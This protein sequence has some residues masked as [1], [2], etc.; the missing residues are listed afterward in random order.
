[1]N[2]AKKMLPPTQADVD[3]AVLDGI[4]LVQQLGF[5]LNDETATKVVGRKSR[6]LTEATLLSAMFLYSGPITEGW[7]V[8]L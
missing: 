3:Q 7:K 5:Q 8:V 1:M 2:M 4:Q 6:L